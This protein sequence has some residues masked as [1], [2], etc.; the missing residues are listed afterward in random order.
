M[1]VRMVR[2]RSANVWRWVL[3]LAGAGL[4]VWAAATFVFGDATQRASR[5]VGAEANFGAERA[6]VQPVEAQTFES[7][8]PLESRELGRL[9]RLRG[10]AESPVRRGAVWVRAAENRRILVRLEPAPPEDARPPFTM[11]SAVDVEGYVQRISRAELQ[12]WT[13]TLGV[14]L[15]RPRPG[16]KFGDLPDSLFARVDSLFIRNFYVSVRPWGI[17]PGA[18]EDRDVGPTP[19]RPEDAA[20]GDTAARAAAAS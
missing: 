8:L 9:V 15:P 18:A 6:P 1:D 19:A 2:G 13:D 11:G 14:V 12:S 4:L 7:L 17:R 20:E 5:G 16:A 3:S 10:V